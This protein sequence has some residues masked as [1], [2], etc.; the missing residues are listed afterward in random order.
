MRQ[1]PFKSFSN[2]FIRVLIAEWRIQNPKFIPSAANKAT[3]QHPFKS[4]SNPFIRVL[5]AEWRI[6]NPKF[7]PSAANKATRQ[8]IMRQH[9]FKSFSNPFIRVLLA[10]WRHSKQISFQVFIKLSKIS[11]AIVYKVFRKTQYSE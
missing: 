4:F 2:P 9:P 3:R 7:I 11:T 1:H 6:Q 8:H 5:L 10:E